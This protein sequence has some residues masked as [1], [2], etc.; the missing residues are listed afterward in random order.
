[1]TET[2]LNHTFVFS[3]FQL[4]PLNNPPPATPYSGSY[5]YYYHY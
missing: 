5:Y 2:D 4:I 3:I 1:M